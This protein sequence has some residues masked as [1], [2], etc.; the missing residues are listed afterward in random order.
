MDFN[1]VRRSGVFYFVGAEAVGMWE[2]WARVD[3]GPGCCWLPW[4]AV[5]VF[6]HVGLKVG[7]SEWLG[8]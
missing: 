6:L 2:R 4:V 3:P 8:E 5:V 7:N 1:L